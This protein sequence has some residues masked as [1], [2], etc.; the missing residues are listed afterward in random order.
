[1]N[2]PEIIDK[3]VGESE[4]T[5]REVFDRARQSAPSIV[6]FDEIDAV[7]ARRGEG[8]EVTERVVSQLLTELDGLAQNP[9]VVVL[10]A[11]NRMEAIDPAILRPGRID[12]HIEVPEPD[13][14]ARRKIL[15]VHTRGKPLGDGVDLDE[16]AEELPGYTGAD[17]EAI[18]REASMRAIRELADDLGP[19]EANERADEVVI[20]EEHFEQARLTVDPS[21]DT[22]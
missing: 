15:A 13:A 8:H 4:K 18:A 7:T 6:F 11:T 16:M 10:A 17:M 1:V 22:R 21:T 12:T 3:Y 20:T 9:N 2:G 5:V 19:E 14:E